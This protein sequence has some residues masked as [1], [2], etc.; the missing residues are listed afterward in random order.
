[1]PSTCGTSAGSS[2]SPTW[3]TW[4]PPR[5]GS[6]AWPCSCSTADRVRAAASRRSRSCRSRSSARRRS[7]AP[8]R[9]PDARL[10][11]AHGLRPGRARQDRAA[12]AR[13]GRRLAEPRPSPR[14]RL[15]RGARP[16]RRD[17][18]RR[19]RAHRSSSAL[20]DGGRGPVPVAT[21][22]AVAPPPADA[23]V[24]AG[25]DDDLAVGLAASPRGRNVAARVTALSPDNLG[26]DRLSVTIAGPRAAA[27]GPAATARRSRCPRRRGVSP[28]GSPG[29]GRRRRSRS[30]SPRAGRRRPTRRSS[31]APAAST[32]RCGRSS[33]TSVWRRL[34]GTRSTRPTSSRRRTGSRT[35]SAAGRRRS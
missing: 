4:P 28:S 3:S 8:R 32:A 19:R 11:R 2:R 17:R 30:R 5:S 14:A 25:Q 15:R 18:R 29:A 34:H 35:R 22:R 13:A 16:D 6:A 31:R 26:V 10:G 7:R 27:C 23:V 1:M 24:L 33:S 9:L 21:P 12:R 20:P